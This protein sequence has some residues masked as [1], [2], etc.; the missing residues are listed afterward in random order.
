MTYEETVELEKHVKIKNE[1]DEI[2]RDFQKHANFKA[3]SYIEKGNRFHIWGDSHNDTYVQ[4]TG[5]EFVYQCRFLNETYD[6]T[7][8]PSA[9]FGYIN[10]KYK[11]LGHFEAYIRQ[12]KAEALK[13][14]IQ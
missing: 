5:G 13:L 10:N 14:S 12:L 7:I 8:T 4:I 11:G 6:V 3:S 9:I 1:A 2:F